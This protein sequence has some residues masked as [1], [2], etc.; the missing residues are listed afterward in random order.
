[1]KKRSTK[2]KAPTVD[3]I[4]DLITDPQEDEEFPLG[5]THFSSPTRWFG[6]YIIK[7][8]DMPSGNGYEITRQGTKVDIR[9]AE[10]LTAIRETV[11][12]SMDRKHFV[13]S[14]IG[15]TSV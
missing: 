4:A 2:K 11:W 1:M 10:A 9:D 7:A 15:I 3:P 12:C 14:P 6:T 13:I 5:F 8:E